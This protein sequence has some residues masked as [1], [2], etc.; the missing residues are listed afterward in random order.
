VRFALL[1]QLRQKAPQ[2]SGRAAQAVP[3][4]RGASN[5]PAAKVPMR[6]SDSR[7]DTDSAND[8]ENASRCCMIDTFL[9]YFSK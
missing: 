2:R 8:L 1:E 4:P 9:L 6:R 5:A 7:R 3:N